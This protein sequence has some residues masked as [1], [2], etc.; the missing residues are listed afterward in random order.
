MGKSEILLTIVAFIFG[1][2]MFVLVSGVI[3]IK[4]KILLHNMKQKSF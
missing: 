1:I 4:L 3:K 2:S